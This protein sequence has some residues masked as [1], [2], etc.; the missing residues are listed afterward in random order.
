VVLYKD[1]FTSV[2]GLSVGS[3]TLHPVA[4]MS[5]MLPMAGSKRPALQGIEYAFL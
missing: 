5:C 1:S 2:R 4:L 3:V